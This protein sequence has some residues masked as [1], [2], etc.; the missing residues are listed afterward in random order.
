M[1]A[2]FDL[3]GIK[4]RH[5]LPD[6]VGASIKLHRAGHEWKACCPFHAD[7][8]PSFTIFADGTRWHCFGCGAGGDVLD[9]LQR[10][11]E[12]SLPDA[13]RMLEG[14]TLPMVV[15]P[16]L[17]PE[18][19]RD[20]TA[21]AVSIW[22]AAQPAAGT[23]ADIYLRSRGLDCRIPESIRF[24]KLAYGPRSPTRPCLVALVAS[25]DHRAVGIHRIFLRDDGLGK[26]DV[27]KPKL[28]L[29]RIRG[30]AVRL[31]PAAR[32]MIIAEGIEDALTL[33]Q[34]LGIAA[35]AAAGAGMLQGLQLPVGATSIIIGADRDKSGEAAARSVAERLAGEGRTVRII[36]P[37]RGFKDFN[38]ELQGKRA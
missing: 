34:E 13:A 32:E 6:I 18:P 27:R 14:G 11:H 21:E 31:A 9:Y 29:G 10:A 35:W 15:Q 4:A 12:V 36:R 2:R 5:P 7:G 26:A 19:D 3:A 17:P 24:A 25:P 37:V 16:A 20:T 28:S 38:A 33:Q 23:L 8:S 30:C 1:N 22:R